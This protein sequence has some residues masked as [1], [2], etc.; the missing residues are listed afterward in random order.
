MKYGGWEVTAV[1]QEGKIFEKWQRMATEWDVTTNGENEWPTVAIGD[2][3][4]IME[5]INQCRQTPEWVIVDGG[6][7]HGN[8]TKQKVQ[9]NI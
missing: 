7:L 8:T 5:M 3:N 4:N 2:G 6:A 1:A 9:R